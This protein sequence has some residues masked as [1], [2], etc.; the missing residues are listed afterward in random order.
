MEFTGERFLPELDIDSE[1][2]IL[3]YQRYKSII[4]ICKG[5][6]ILDAACGEGY[7]SNM[8]SDVARSVYGID[9]DH[10]T[11]QAAAKKYSKENLKYVEGSVA[12]L[13]FEDAMFD[14]VV[15]F[16]TIEHVNDA[17]QQKF[18]KEISRVLKP[19]GVL[20]ISSP[21]K[22]NYSDIPNFSNKFHV[23]E[24]YFEEFESLLRS[25]FKNINFYYQG[26]LCN[27]YIFNTQKSVANIDNEIKLRDAD[28]TQAE[29]IIAVC[30]NREIT[31]Q[32]ESVICDVDN[33]YYKMN[34]KIIELKKEVG[35]PEDIIEQKENY[36]CEQR[37]MLEQRDGQIRELNGIVIQKENYICEQRNMLE[38]C[39]G[40]IREL[41]GIV[42]QKENY[43]CE[44]RGMLE[45]CDGQIR[46]KNETIQEQN[47]IIQEKNNIIQ[48]IND[49][50][51]EM[52]DIV[53]QKENYINEQHDM[54]RMKE[55][56]INQFEEFVT[57]RGIRKLY[58]LFLKKNN[59]LIG[60]LKK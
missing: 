47:N 29:Y 4:S 58:S 56:K 18:I 54:L 52:N 22:L 37:K 34:R 9:L 12:E 60:S 43:I 53:I 59:S 15:S 33:R 39:D 24:L 14:V 3:H 23:K 32:I 11:I 25:K 17:T 31:E 26:R 21:D 42:I 27:S 41:D 49:I 20:I 13:E 1:I 16:E 38:Q 45:Q 46:E 7:G 57:K 50:I 2:A 30:S 5:K 40:R 48:E 44:Q 35:A 19:D 36:I 55:E 10:D 28:K 6:V 8:L 51:Q